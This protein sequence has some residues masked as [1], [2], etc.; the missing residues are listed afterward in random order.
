MFSNGGATKNIV[1]LLLRLINVLSYVIVG[2]GLARMRKWSTYGLIVLIIISILIPFHNLYISTTPNIPQESLSFSKTVFFII[3]YLIILIF[4]SKLFSKENKIASLEIP[5]VDKYKIVFRLVGVYFLLTGIYVIL[6]Y[7]FSRYLL[8]GGIF[9]FFFIPSTLRFF[10]VFVGIVIGVGLISLKKWSIY[11]IVLKLFLSVIDPVYFYNFYRS[12]FLFEFNFGEIAFFVFDMLIDIA[13]LISLTSLMRKFNK[14]Q[15]DLEESEKLKNVGENQQNKYGYLYKFSI[16]TAAVVVACLLMIF[17]K[18]NNLNLSLKKNNKY[19]TPTPTINSEEEDK[20]THYDDIVIENYEIVDTSQSPVFST[21]LNLSTRFLYR[22]PNLVRWKN[23][24]IGINI[25]NFVERVPNSTMNNKPTESTHLYNKIDSIRVYNLDSKESFNLQL[26]KPIIESYYGDVI[27]QL[28]ENKLYFGA[29]SKEGFGLFEYKLDLP[30]S[31]NSKVIKLPKSIGNKI[32]KI[33]N[34]YIS[35]FC[36]EGCSYTLFNSTSSTETVLTRMNKA[37]NGYNEDRT[38]KLIGIDSKGRMI[39]DSVKDNMIAAVP[40][41]N[42]KLTIPLIKKDKLPTKI[43]DF[44]MINGVDKIL[45]LG[46]LRAYIY[47]INQNKFTEIQINQENNKWSSYWAKTN[48]VICL[49]PESKEIKKETVS[50]VDLTTNN[51]LEVPLD[52]CFDKEQKTV[53]ELF[54]ELKLP[55]NYE[56]KDASLTFETYWRYL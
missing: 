19:L 11:L 31:K 14:N 37:A 10:N 53:D 49:S 28:F 1:T 33:G 46:E 41:T 16:F 3:V 44:S 47:D 45:M 50:A 9:R 20:A 4:K 36:Y 17:V 21:G 42:E 8:F 22:S 48:N 23:Y 32:E 55:D 39:I 12:P 43:V 51:Y 40:L 2:Y 54:K 5:M 18:N 26:E 52:D 29:S 7:F 13:I 56:L 25:V 27:S 38:E 30:P 24:L 6:V 34:V 35:S 15:G